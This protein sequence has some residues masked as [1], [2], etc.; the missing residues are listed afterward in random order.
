[1]LGIMAL[2][3]LGLSSPGVWAIPGELRQGNYPIL[4]VLLFW[5]VGLGLAWGAWR[6]ARQYW[7]HGVLE[8]RPEPLP[9]SLGGYVGGVIT[10]PRGLRLGGDVVLRL[11][12]MKARTTGS[13]KKRSTSERV[14]WET[15]MELAQAALRGG[16]V[17]DL[18]VLFH[19]PRGPARPAD[20]RNRDNRLLWRLQVEAPLADGKSAVSTSFEVPVFDV[21]DHVS[22]P[23]PGE[24]LLSVQRERPIRHHLAEAGVTE[25]S[26]A[27]ARVWRFKARDLG[28]A[29]AFLAVFLLATGGIAW[30]VPAWPIKLGFGFFF[31][32]LLAL[33]PGVIWR[34]S[35]LRLTAREIE[36]RRSSWRGWKRQ[37]L[38][39]EEVGDLTLET[40]MTSGDRPY[41][42]LKLVG[43]PGVDP[44][45]PHPAEHFKARKARYR[46]RQQPDD[47]ERQRVLRETPRFE[48]VA[49][50]YLQGQKS[51]ERVR[52]HLLAA[53]TSSD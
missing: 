30:F 13:G 46:W 15:E 6:R 22:A 34:D 9:G 49:A 51:A 40:S 41:L 7:R 2:A 44:A 37:V 32:L 39:R 53:I 50:G 36:V 11:R 23:A 42:R 28:S 52:D 3:C 10:I 33:L 1:M 48:V 38:R 21:G 27:D 45:Q 8:F 29:V 17:R 24:T 47:P 20:D 12:N 31:V 5:V 18:P 14:L 43:L 25:T 4:L 26:E 35:E 16:L 19:V